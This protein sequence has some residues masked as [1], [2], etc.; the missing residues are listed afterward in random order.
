MSVAT[1]MQIN[2]REVSLKNVAVIRENVAIDVLLLMRIPFVC[3]D[4]NA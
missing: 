2:S 1:S 3:S 4:Y